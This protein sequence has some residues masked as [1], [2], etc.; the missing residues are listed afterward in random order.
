VERLGVVAVAV[1]ASLKAYLT[2]AVQVR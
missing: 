1:A 2:S